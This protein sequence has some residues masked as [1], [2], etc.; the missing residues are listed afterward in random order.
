MFLQEK[1]LKEMFWKNYNGK[2]RA[3]RYQFECDIRAGGADLVTIEKYQENYQV[4]SFEFKL[5]DIKKAILQAEGNLPFVNKSWIVI[6]IEKADL[7]NNKY[8]N[9]LDSDMYVGV[10]G[11]HE[12]GRWEIIYQP[13][14]QY[15]TNS[16]QAIIRLC[17]KEV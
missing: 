14:I 13:K 11:V 10:I 16:N 9:K 3:L 17:M 2:N 6:P 7:I 12:G 1:E 8:R 4:N 15:V 5:T